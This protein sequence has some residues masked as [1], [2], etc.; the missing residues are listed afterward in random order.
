MKRILLSMFGG[1]LAA[2]MMCASLWAQ[3]TAEISGTARDQSGA[4]LPGV[5]VR[6]TQTDTGVTRDSLTNETGSY[7]LPNL[8]IGPYRLE[9]TLPGFRTYA[10]TGIILQVNSNP[11]INVVLEV[12]QVSEQVEV[13]ANAALVETRN[14]GVGQ[15]V[16]NARILELPLNG[17]Q[18]VE[19]ISLSGAATP[20]P[21][22][23]GSNRDNFATQSFSVA[24]GL[25][26]G[27]TFTLD[28]ATHNNMQSN[29]YISLPF[30]D[31]LQEFKVETSASN[32]Q[33]GMKSA[34]T[35]SLVTKS[36]TNELHGDL[37]EFVRNGM[38]NARNAFALQRD[39]IKRNQ[40]GGTAGGA[41]LQNK[42]FFFAG[43]QA[44]RVRQDPSDTI[45]YVPTP[46]MMAGDFTTFASAA[47]NGGRSISLKAPFA[48]N[49]IDPA[50]LSKPAL[51]FSTKLPTAL[52]GCGKV[53]Y[54]SP[55][56]SNGYQ[57]IGRIDYQKSA[58]HSIF[59]RYLAE[60][61]VSPSSWETTHNPLNLVG[62]GNGLRID[63]LAQAFTLGSTYLL[64][65]TVVNSFRLTANRVAGGK[66]PPD[67]S[68]AGLGS[69][70]IGLHYF[71]YTPHDPR[72]NVTGGFNLAAQGGPT[73]MADFAAS[74][75]VSVLRGNHQISFGAQASAWW[76]NSY[77]GTYQGP[78]T[79][80]G[81][82]FGL[83]M[84]DFLMG[85]AQDFV[86]APVAAQGKRSKY[87]G[88][89]GADTWKVNA[90]LT[91]NYGLRWEPFFPLI[92]LDGSGVHFDMDAL[93]KGIKS[94]RFDNTPPGVFFSG[95]PGYPGKAGRYNKW[96]NFSPRLGLAW[97]PKGDGR[98]SIRVS[99]GT[100]YDF[101]QTHY[102]YDLSAEPPFLPRYQ[103]TGINFENPW[104]NFPGGDPF[105]LPYGNAVG[106]NA[107]FGLYSIVTA[108][109]YNSPNMRVNQWNLSVQRQVGRD[110]L[111]SG[112]YIG[113]STNHMWTSQPI[114]PSVFLGLGPCTLN[115]VFYST[116]STTGNTDQRRRFNL[117]PTIS[118]Q[119]AQYYGYVIKIDTGGTAS[120]NGMLLSVQRRVA[121]GMTVSGNYT[122]SHCIGDPW[123]DSP[124]GGNAANSGWTNPDSR[125]FDRGNCTTG[126]SDRRHVVNVSGVAQTPRF[127]NSALRAVA[128]NWS[129]SP[130]F[131]VLSGGYFSITT[132]QDRALNGRNPQRVSQVLGNPYGDGTVNKFLNPAAFVLPDLGTYGTAGMGSI[133]GPMTWQFDTSF[134]R[135]FQL[136]ET[137]KLE[138]RAEAFNLLNKMRMDDSKL[139]TTL[140]TGNFGAVTGSLDPRILQFALK[141]VF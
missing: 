65:A 47:C 35:V 33:T 49:R 141:Y 104:A 59:G 64:S 130:I 7:V 87:V 103:L 44:T 39:T 62:S 74:D 2:V 97:D 86:M 137:K 60:S 93:R 42:L 134:S 36:G 110:W 118:K 23:N 108:I 82:A 20:A 78:F 76:V 53:I 70:D 51:Q 8:P 40:F 106:R 81:S 43:Y 95:D 132:T 29:G 9:A 38:F 22:V 19:L 11:S 67:L 56:I 66:F 21:V 14:S 63:A 109:D 46:A 94:T 55:N 102:Q 68:K 69:A 129:F 26:S 80:N 16:E 136:R 88:L 125:R 120:Y 114:N 124:I 12:G 83:G 30:P 48:N 115:G 123:S 25:N 119:A 24:G 37:F 3:A 28:G 71:N 121:R 32:A 111:L 131:K 54:G 90:K 127:S 113:T 52:D 15:V 17:R 91:V 57:V 117:D 10:Q 34:G 50:L 41:I 72:F 99:G 133:R 92:N 5:E 4:V 126:Q 27:L 84:A 58:K 13:Q 45:S 112:S 31:A 107:P 6:A 105:P 116:C 140:N 98:T 77:S 96:W 18:I 85:Q 75:D 122:W 89:Y 100:F 73:R 128:S 79:F 138:F 101:P 135:T 61:L 139:I 1:V